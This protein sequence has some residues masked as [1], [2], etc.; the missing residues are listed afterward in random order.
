MPNRETI[1][2]GDAVV[3][4][5]VHALDELGDREP[6]AVLLG[7]EEPGTGLP[8]EVDDEVEDELEEPQG[9]LDAIRRIQK[10]D[11]LGET[12]YSID[13]NHLKKV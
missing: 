6:H 9:E 13:L 2:V 12:E 10:A 3:V 11:D 1:G 8:V 7:I 4:E 5:G